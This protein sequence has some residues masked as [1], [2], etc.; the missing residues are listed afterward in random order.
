MT[1]HHIKKHRDPVPAH[2]LGSNGLANRRALR[3]WHSAKNIVTNRKRLTIGSIKL[4]PEPGLFGAFGLKSSVFA[5]AGHSKDRKISGCFEVRVSQLTGR[6]HV[7]PALF[8]LD[9]VYAHKEIPS[10]AVRVGEVP[11][12]LRHFAKA[13]SRS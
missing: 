10:R 7:S 1:V 4:E 12:A 6:V 13:L 2:E 3:L 8:L 9:E 5:V 11:R